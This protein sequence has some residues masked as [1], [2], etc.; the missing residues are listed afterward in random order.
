MSSS[1]EDAPVFMHF[2]RPEAVPYTYTSR[3]LQVGLSKYRGRDNFAC[4]LKVEV[5][6]LFARTL[7]ASIS[8]HVKDA[9]VV[10]HLQKKDIIRN[11]CLVQ[12]NMR[13]HQK[14]SSIRIEL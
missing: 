12:R 9:S 7:H 13:M 1:T 8:S 2:L 3:T 11:S 4:W 14:L 10:G 6:H 5:G